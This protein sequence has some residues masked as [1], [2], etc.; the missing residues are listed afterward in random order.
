M[1]C[2]VNPGKALIL[3]ELLTALSVSKRFVHSTSLCP[4]PDPERACS[5]RSDEF[6]CKVRGDTEAMSLKNHAGHQENV[7]RCGSID[8]HFY[9]LVAM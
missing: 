5:S 6:L 4:F 2:Y 1:T 8:L 9:L 7:G 3:V